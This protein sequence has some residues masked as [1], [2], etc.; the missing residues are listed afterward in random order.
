MSNRR[1]NPFTQWLAPAALTMALLAPAVAYAGDVKIGAE[2]LATDDEGKLTAEGKKAATD[3][4]KSEPG[5]ELWIAHVW[6]KIDNGGPGPLYVEFIGDRPGGGKYTALRHEK[7]DYQGEKYVS[8]EI[9]LDGN[10]G[11]NK[12]KTYAVKV[13]QV[14]P[15]GKDIVLA[16]SKITIEYVEA[17][18]D[19]GGGDEGGEDTDGGEEMSD[20]DAL[21][22]LAGGDEANASGDGPPPVAPK[23]KGC[24]VDATGLG[25]FSGLLV[26]F[27]IGA[28]AGRR[29]R[30]RRA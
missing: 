24:S 10:T 18:P 11:F 7:S 5:E 22:T 12:G 23:K 14:S 21:D 2:P 19:E 9:E 17:K 26:V 6:A 27:G 30:R 15:K 3:T 16:Q 4:L 28:L 8:M 1:R 13:L 29:R 20:Q 25:G